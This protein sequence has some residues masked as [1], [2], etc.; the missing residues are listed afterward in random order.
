M[1][2]VN[3]LRHL[4]PNA[5]PLRD[6]V[7]RDDGGGP[8][9]AAWS[10]PDPQPTLSELEAA[11]TAYDAAET[12]RQTD[13]TAL[14]QRVLDLAQTA[15]GVRIDQLTAA[16]VRALFAILLHKEGALT[17]LGTIRPLGEWVR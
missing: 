3:A 10:L 5:E 17:A 16:Q 2:I 4:Y 15:V 12:Q 9:I 1:N 11:S 14:R 8:Y 7:L 6:Y 13:A